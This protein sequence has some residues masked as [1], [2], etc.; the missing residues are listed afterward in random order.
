MGQGKDKMLR[1]AAREQVQRDNKAV[2]QGFM[3]EISAQP[4]WQRFWFCIKMAFKWHRLQRSMK[5]QIAERKKLL[6]AAKIMDSGKSKQGAAND[7]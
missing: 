5:P 4:F 3:L 7:G 2:Y 6:K 1:R